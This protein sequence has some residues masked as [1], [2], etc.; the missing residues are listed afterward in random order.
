MVLSSAVAR[1][2]VEDM[3]AFHAERDGIKAD[4]IAAR[5]LR[6]LQEYYGGELTLD[7]VRSL[8]YEL[9]DYA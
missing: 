6:S 4:G 9:K 1:A 2:F 8:F 3:R 5:Q 7:N